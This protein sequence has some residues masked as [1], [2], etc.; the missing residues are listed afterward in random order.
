MSSRYDYPDLGSDPAYCDGLGAD[1][2]DPLY[3]AW[4]D[5]IYGDTTSFHPTTDYDP[6]CSRLCAISAADHFDLE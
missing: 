1:P 4:C 2:P 5:A 3:C 6:Y